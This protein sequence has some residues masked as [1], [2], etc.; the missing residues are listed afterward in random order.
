MLF[1]IFKYFVLVMLLLFAMYWVLSAVEEAVE[2]RTRWWKLFSH[3]VLIALN[4]AVFVTLLN[5]WFPK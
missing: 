1:L 3:G 4:T 2:D 5:T